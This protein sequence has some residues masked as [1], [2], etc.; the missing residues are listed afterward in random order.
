MSDGSIRDLGNG[1]RSFGFHGAVI[2]FPL[3]SGTYFASVIVGPVIHGCRP[4]SSAR[5]HQRDARSRT[6]APS[7]KAGPP[8]A[9]STFLQVAMSDD[10]AFQR[11][12]DHAFELAQ[13]E[14]REKYDVA[15]SL[16]RGVFS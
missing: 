16:K 2:D 13:A 1:A 9:A 6:K 12:L 10:E 15:A 3:Q 5:R 8:D 14:D 11:K 7:E 4:Q